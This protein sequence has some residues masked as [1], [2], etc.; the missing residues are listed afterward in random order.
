V[1]VARLRLRPIRY[2][3]SPMFGSLRSAGR[4]KRQDGLRPAFRCFGQT[5]R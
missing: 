4:I 1:P 3:T 2:K 5:F